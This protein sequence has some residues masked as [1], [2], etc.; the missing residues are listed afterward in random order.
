MPYGTNRRSRIDLLLTPAESNPDQRLIYLEVK[1]TTWTNG[2]TA[3]FPDTVTE[4]GQK[5]L[6]ELMG[7]L[8][9]ARAVLVPCLSRPDVM[10]FAP[11]DEADPRYGAL[12]RDAPDKPALRVLPCCFRYQSQRNQLARD[13]SAQEI[14]EFVAI[15]TLR[16]RG[17]AT[18]CT[19]SWGYISHAF[20]AVRALS[21]MTTAY[22]SRPLRRRKTL[23]RSQSSE[24]P[25]AA[26]QQHQGIQLQPRRHLAR[27]RAAGIAWPWHLYAVGQGGRASRTISRFPCQQPLAVGRHDPGDLHECGLRHGRSRHVPSEKR[28]QYSRQKPVRVCPRGHRVLV[29][30]LLVDVW[31]EAAIDSAGM[32]FRS[33]WSVLRSRR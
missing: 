8:P 32:Y 30:W 16:W 27:M 5:H 29:R 7:V 18:T 9:E 17:Q 33:E 31:I 6:V 15:G 22:Q 19:S 24:R 12:F 14:S 21:L 20:F 26:A 10:D 25:H 3:L 4:R 23:A 2:T 28:R 11:G 13:T 1:N